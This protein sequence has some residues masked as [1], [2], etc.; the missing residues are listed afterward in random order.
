MDKA[1]SNYVALTGKSDD[2]SRI[3]IWEEIPTTNLED[4]HNIFVQLVSFYGALYAWVSNP[5]KGQQVWR[6]YCG[7]NN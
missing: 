5:V 1:I 3:E 6:I 2:Y 7:I 4:N